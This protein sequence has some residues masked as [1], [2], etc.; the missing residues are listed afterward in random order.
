MGFYGYQ[1]PIIWD[2]IMDTEKERFGFDPW[3]IVSGL[4]RCLGCFFYSSNLVFMTFIKFLWTRF[5][6][7]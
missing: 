3:R 4:V 1:K 7:N 6:V 2:E 5:R